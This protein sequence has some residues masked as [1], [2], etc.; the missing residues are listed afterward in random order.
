MEI[1]NQ[2]I[3]AGAKKNLVIDFI[4]A[5]ADG[6]REKSLDTV[7]AVPPWRGYTQIY[8]IFSG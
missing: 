2:F 6:L 3:F 8:I 5:I 1:W 7:L 4:I